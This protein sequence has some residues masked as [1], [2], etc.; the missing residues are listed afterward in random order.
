MKVEFNSKWA[1]R[2][3]ERV[4]RES[5]RKREN[6]NDAMNQPIM[7]DEVKKAISKSYLNIKII[8]WLTCR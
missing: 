3:S 5:E 1:E 7:L 4:K 6:L 8:T 2:I